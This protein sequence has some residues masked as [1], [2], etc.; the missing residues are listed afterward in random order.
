MSTNVNSGLLEE[1]MKYKEVLCS[2]QILDIRIQAIKTNLAGFK[3]V[4]YL[5][6]M[7]LY[8]CFFHL[9]VPINLYESLMFG[10]YHLIFLLKAFPLS[11]GANIM[12]F[13]PKKG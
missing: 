12:V 7:Y 1:R 6:Y 13:L 11:S 5:S 4:N 8:I 3:L 2:G 10:W 9:I